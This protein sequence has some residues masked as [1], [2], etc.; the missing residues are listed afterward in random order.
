MWIINA[1]GTKAEVIE[2]VTAQSWPAIILAADLAIIKAQGRV[3]D[4]PDAPSLRARVEEL[5]AQRAALDAPTERETFDF[6]RAYVLKVIELMQAEPIGV[7]A[8]INR[9]PNDPEG[10]GDGEVSVSVT[11]F[12]P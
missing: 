9:L 2:A 7:T 5:T 3:D 11:G 4:H 10:R 12:P 8:R 6:T 1:H